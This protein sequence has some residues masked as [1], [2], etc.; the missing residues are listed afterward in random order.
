MIAPPPMQR[1]FGMYIGPLRLI[2]ALV[3]SCVTRDNSALEYSY[4]DWYIDR[5]VNSA[6]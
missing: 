2:D 3:L 4:I 6:I 5:K 1:A